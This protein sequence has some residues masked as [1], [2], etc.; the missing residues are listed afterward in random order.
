M[1][2]LRR[3][4]G[5]AVLHAID[6]CLW[7]L[8]AQG[9]G[10]PRWQTLRG[11]AARPPRPY[12]TLYTGGGT[13][14]QR[15]ERLERLIAAGMR[16]GYR[17]AKLE[18]LFDCV[19]EDRIVDFV[20]RD[21]RCSAMR[22]SSTSTSAIASPML[23]TPSRHGEQME[24]IVDRGIQ[25]LIP[26]DTSRRRTTRRNWDG[27]HYDFM[28]RV[29]AT[30]RG[31]GLY[32]RRQPMVE[33]VFAQTKFNRGLDRFRR[34]GRGA[35]RAEWRLITATHNLLKLHRHALTAA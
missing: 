3:G 14:A 24:R 23:T 17:A 8:V 4:L 5:L 26:P 31:G 15:V 9:R 21:A 32:R 13:Y 2:S 27:G 12:V 7:D 34:R 30:D 20:A 18:P 1:F 6:V 19:P 25:V 10:E 33:P 35:V 22:A 28:R 16:L 11:A 29:L